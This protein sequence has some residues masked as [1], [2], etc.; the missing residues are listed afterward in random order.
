MRTG[1]LAGRSTFI[2]SISLNSSDFF[3]ATPPYFV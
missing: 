3:F 1:L 2:F